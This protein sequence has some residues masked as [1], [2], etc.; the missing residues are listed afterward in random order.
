[1]GVGV[2]LRRSWEGV[3]VR[4]E[5]RMN[6][7]SG[8]EM[9]GCLCTRRGQAI[10]ETP[11]AT[12]P[13]QEMREVTQPFCVI[14]T[15]IPWGRCKYYHPVL[16]MK[17]LRHRKV[18]ELTQVCPASR[19]QSQGSNPRLATLP[20][21]QLGALGLGATAASLGPGQP[22]QIWIGTQ[23]FRFRGLCSHTARQTPTSGLESAHRGLA[24]QQPWSRGL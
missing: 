11:A 19:Q 21:G 2:G 16:E 17:T 15:T 10:V 7:G 3:L 14:F 23:P 13:V 20:L 24:G 5:G 4:G 18:K 9:T 8:I 22:P 12:E 1:M 6:V